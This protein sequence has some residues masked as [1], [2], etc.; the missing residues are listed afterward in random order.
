ML[1]LG[2]KNI[3]TQT[4]LADGTVNIGSVYRRYCKTN[5][6]GVPAFS[7]TSNGVTLNHAGIYHI[8]A[9]LVGTGATAGDVSVQLAENGELITGA[10]STET[11]TTATTEFR[12]FVIDYYIKVDKDCVL[13]YPTTEAKTISLVNVSEDIDTTF[14]SV[15]LNISKEV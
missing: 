6:C 10:I 2:L 5:Q 11:I 12:T 1:L 3:G 9:V 15:V 14:T 13:G 8:T 4:V 7:V